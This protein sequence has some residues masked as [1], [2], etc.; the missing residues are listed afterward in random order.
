LGN[1]SIFN[2]TPSGVNEETFSIGAACCTGSEVLSA[3]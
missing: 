3:V 1:V 2:T